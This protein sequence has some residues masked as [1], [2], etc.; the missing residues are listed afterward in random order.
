MK[1]QIDMENCEISVSVQELSF[2]SRT[3]RGVGAFMDFTPFKCSPDRIMR[4]GMELRCRYGGGLDFSVLGNCDSIYQNRNDWVLEKVREVKRVSE[5]TSPFSDLR[6][7]CESVLCAYM[8]MQERGAEKVVLRIFV[9]SRDGE[10]AK[11]FECALSRKF[12]ENMWQAVCE[13]AV[14]FVALEA[15]RELSGKPRLEKMA[16]PY[17]EIREGQRDFINDAFYAA[18]HGRRLMVS[19]PTG[20]GKTVSALYPALRAIGKGH[21]DKVFYLTAKT[22]TGNAAADACRQMARQ[23]DTLRCIFVTAKDRVCPMAGRRDGACAFVCSLCGEACGAPFEARRDAALLELLRDNNVIETGIIEA[24]AKKYSVCPYELSLDASEYCEVGICD[25]NY[26][27]D[28]TV[29]FR[30]YFKCEQP[31]RYMFLVDEAHN[32]PDR[33][34]EMYSAEI[35]SNVFMQLHKTQHEAVTSCAPLMGALK[36]VLLQMRDIVK[37][38]AEE[39]TMVGEKRYGYWLSRELPEKLGLAFTQFCHIARSLSVE[40]PEASETL[41]RAYSMARGYVTATN[42]ANAKFVFFAESVDG[43]LKAS[44]RCLDPSEIIDSMLQ[45]AKAAVLF[46]ATLSP[47]DYFA[48][49]LGCGGAPQ[50]ELDSPYD[51]DRLCVVGVNS[52]STRYSSRDDSVP[53]IAEMIFSAIEAKAG[54][55][56]VY[57]PSYEYM[58]KVYKAFAEIAYGCRCILQKQ[59]MTIAERNKFLEKFKANREETLVGFCVLGGAF[60]EGVDL[61]GDRLIGTVIVGMG[62]PKLSAEQNILQNYF[63]ET[64]ENGYDYAYTYPAMIKISQAAGRVIRSETD[65]GVV[66]LIDDRYAEAPI[67]RLMPKSWRR[68]KFASDPEQLANIVQGFWERME[69][70]N[71]VK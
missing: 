6:F 7:L 18:V 29:R 52:V 25:Y 67:L 56:I 69:D 60:A 23:V 63:E 64:R 33:A 42:Y 26:V 11:G 44:I 57:F 17:S 49:I 70:D 13:R 28:D 39:E 62:L 14:P 40:Q 51:P 15:E 58:K 2:F 3:R 34:R 1:L 71:G 61:S 22:V 50:L 55:Y 54:N 35:D 36:E 16:F 21:I 53:E 12:A 68:I 20:I 41:E 27:F 38:C 9:V 5:N 65:C 37:R 24:V 31:D 8:L 4:R 45:S 47:M 43:R 46:S 32:L 30:R 59:G 10:R 48:D 66:I 19:A